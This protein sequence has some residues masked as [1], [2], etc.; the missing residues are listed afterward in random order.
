MKE[1]LS[2]SIILSA[3]GIIS[4]IISLLAIPIH[5]NSQGLTNYGQYIFFHFIL[6]LGL[7]LNLGFGKITTICL[8]KYY[9]KVKLIIT[10][11]INLTVKFCF[12]YLIIYLVIDLIFNLNHNFFY[13]FLGLLL[14]FVYFSFEGI[15]IG[16]KKFKKISFINFIFFSLSLNIPS[17][18][19]YFKT[20]TL[21]EIFQYSLIIKLVA[22]ILMT[23]EYRKNLIPKKNK[24][25]IFIK[26][27]KLN[28]GW[29]ALTYINSQISNF[30]DKYLIKLFLGTDLLSKYSIPQ[31]L[32]GKLSIFSQGFSAFLLQNLTVKKD[33]D[34]NLILSIIFFLYIIPIISFVTFPI[35]EVFLKFWLKSN[36][37]NIIFSIFKIFM[38][39]AI[40]SSTSHLIISKF[41]ASLKIKNNVKIEL[42]CLIPFAIILFLSTKYNYSI[43][44]VS[45]IMLLKETILLTLRLNFFKKN[46]K[47]IFKKYYYNLIFIFIILYLSFFNIVIF[48]LFILLIYLP[49]IVYDTYK[50]YTSKNI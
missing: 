50:L 1:L 10:E 47:I 15:F 43:I 25:K 35:F 14:T 8:G 21:E 41:E 26:N 19:L 29:V 23:Y 3:P 27:I 45:I 13:Y 48:Y 42:Y 22:I 46:I 33:K 30:I 2:K 6:S 20:F 38:V 24:S 39:Y 36:Y 18:L 17:L 37:E 11:N 7:L 32:S 12:F 34:K 16:E 5:L 44:F 28:C 40:F 9:Q 31:Q 4:L 49:F